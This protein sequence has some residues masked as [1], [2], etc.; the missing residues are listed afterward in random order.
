M[1]MAQPKRT[2]KSKWD[3]CF[4]SLRPIG[5]ESSDC[6]V[7]LWTFQYVR[8]LVQTKFAAVNLPRLPLGVA[9]RV[10]VRVL[11]IDGDATS[12]EVLKSS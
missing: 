3:V 1:R 10:A 12:E 6:I 4:L 5:G 7:Y 2:I 11:S 8:P 9:V